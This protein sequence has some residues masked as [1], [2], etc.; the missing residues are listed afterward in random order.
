M[1]ERRGRSR[2]ISWAVVALMLP[3]LYVGS[4]FLV[5]RRMGDVGRTVRMFPQSWM[6]DAYA[7]LLAIERQFTPDRHMGGEFTGITDDAWH[8]GPFARSPG[9]WWDRWLDFGS[10]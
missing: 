9:W 3:V 5:S 4:Y 1:S 8:V 7:P 2:W 10:P 6:L